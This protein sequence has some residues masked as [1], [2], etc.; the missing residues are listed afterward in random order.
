MCTVLKSVCVQVHREEIATSF[1]TLGE[2]VVCIQLVYM[3]QILGV[4]AGGP[5]D[6][7]KL[8][9]G[10]SYNNHCTSISNGGS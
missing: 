9:A 5:L 1:D 8:C 7:G 10:R 2:R 6:C 4:L 3:N